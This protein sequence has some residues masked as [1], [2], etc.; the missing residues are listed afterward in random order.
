MFYLIVYSNTIA[1]WKLL[2]SMVMSWL[3]YEV[4][5]YCLMGCPL[6][7]EFSVV[8][9]RHM[10]WV[11]YVVNTEYSGS[12]CECG[13]DKSTCKIIIN[14]FVIMLSSY[15]HLGCWVCWM[16]MMFLSRN[17]KSSMSSTFLH[18]TRS[19]CL[20]VF[21][22]FYSLLLKFSFRWKKIDTILRSHTNV[23]YDDDNDEW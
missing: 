7:T 1:I 22:G 8:L 19:F 15:K 13:H 9:L 14:V 20:A 12:G 4:Y 21:V 6:P 17:L 5:C 23:D 10:C 11:L 3:R 2:L 18:W 16:S